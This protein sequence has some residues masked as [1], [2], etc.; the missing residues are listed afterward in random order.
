M[1]P[2]A[3]PA[4]IAAVEDVLK[5]VWVT[6]TLES[7]L[8][9]DMILYE[10]F[11]ETTEYTDSDG[12]R[13]SIPLRTGRT[14]GVGAR[15]VGEKLAPPDHQKVGKAIYNYKNLYLQIQVEGPVVARMETNR[16][17]CV[18]EIDFEVNNGLEDMKRD[19]QRQLHGFGDA[20]VTLVGLAADATNNTTF[21]LGAGNRAIVD[22]GWLYEGQAIDIGTLADPTLDAEGV[23]IV[24]IDDSGA[25]V[26]ITVDASHTVT[27]GSHIFL[28]GNRGGTA[29]HPAVH[30]RE[31]NGL[32]NTVDDTVEYGGIDPSDPGKGFWR[33]NVLDNGGSGRDLSIK[34]MNDA[35]RKTRQK[36]GTVTD[37]IGSL[38]L[39]Q[40]YYE[41]LQSQVRFA[42]DT[43]LASGKVDGPQFNQV[44]FVGDPAAIPGRVYFLVKKALMMFSAGGI[45]WQ[46]QTAGGNILAWRQ[47]YDSFMARAAKYAQIGTNKRRVLTVLDDINEPA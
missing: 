15:D 27:A 38:G 1:P 43:K 40:E 18:R 47:D 7:Q 17:S 46:N 30:S 24:G 13:A 35:N 31:L 28:H 9:E 23:R 41:L 8:Q 22:A 39:Q 2:V 4:T 11:D 26:E 10:W 45:S 20:A 32:G 16:Q 34:L 5:E 3:N 14:G 21:N 36:G 42:G 25:D 6:D 19:I 12:L 33:A 29:D 37:I 44:S